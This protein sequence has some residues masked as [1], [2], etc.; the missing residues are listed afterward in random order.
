VQLPLRAPLT[1]KL[2]PAGGI[3]VT[4][5]T[6]DGRPAPE[7]F[8]VAE[9]SGGGG[10]LQALH[11]F[12]HAKPTAAGELLLQP[13]E[14]G[15]YRVE[16]QHRRFSPSAPSAVTVTTEVAAATLRLRPALSVRGVMVDELGRPLAGLAFI[17]ASQRV[18]S[19]PD[20]SFAVEGLAP[21]EYPL[22]LPPEDQV[23]NDGHRE[24]PRVLA[25][26]QSAIVEIPVGMQA[27][28]RSRKG[29]RP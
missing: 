16:A 3:R 19:G 10:D 5:L 28:A 29:A 11:T 26:D 2:V 20:G 23:T 6:P 22:A 24:E 12:S 27:R 13:L 21:G 18:V 8:V 25:G 15:E 1:V 7:A 4:I 14:P 17:I 9:K